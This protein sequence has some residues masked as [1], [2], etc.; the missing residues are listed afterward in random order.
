MIQTQNLLLRSLPGDICQAV[1]AQSDLVH[2]DLRES[3]IEPNTLIDFVDFPESGVMSLLQPMDDGTLIEIANIGNE[4]M[5][6]ATT[7]FEVFEIGEKAFCQ[8]E[9]T[10]NRIATASFGL[11]L[12]KYPL[13]RKKCHR[14]VV[15]LLDQI[16]RTA[17]C[18]RTHSVEQ[19]C[20]RWVLATNDRCQNKAFVLTQ[21]FLS[22]MLGV[23]RTSV[24]QA[25]GNLSDLG[26][27]SYVRG[28]ISVLNREGLER[29]SCSC[30]KEINAYYK[31]VMD[32]EFLP[33]LAA[34]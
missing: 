30:Y 27:I 16:S 18:Y 34:I 32:Q 24:N 11:L 5:V 25:A 12:K 19:R 33:I 6:G 7:V 28:K 20:A 21:E 10:S 15:T 22:L 9:G 29:A 17:A 8:V 23:S 13:L 4:G 26:L 1:L 14:Y 31:K 3:L 2:L